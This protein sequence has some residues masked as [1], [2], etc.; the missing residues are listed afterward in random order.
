MQ[1]NE[2][3]LKKRA[4]D[5]GDKLK[6]IGIS[7][8]QTADAVVKHVDA[9]D[10]KRPIHYHRATSDCSDVYQVRG[11]PHVMLIDT[12]GK[13]VFKGHP[14]TR[15]D[16][17]ADFDTLLKGEAITGPG[18]EVDAPKPAAED[19]APA[20]AMDFDAH[21]SLCDKFAADIGP[22]LQKN[23]SISASAKN[24][25]RAFCVF[26]LEQKI[27]PATGESSGDFKNYRVLV[28]KQA[29]IDACKAQI[30]ENVK[31]DGFEVVL[32]EHAI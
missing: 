26:V 6:I 7:I 13:I 5:W 20:K 8:D 14:A 1:H 19:G 25:P 2:D 10:W 32:R 11:V 30:E 16:L 12:N 21:H 31:G 28:G 9:K 23:E 17:E 27:N 24:M 18:T 4:A 22:A 29:D 15:P 3:M